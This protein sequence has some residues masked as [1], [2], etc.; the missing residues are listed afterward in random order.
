MLYILVFYVTRV[1][2]YIYVCYNVIFEVFQGKYMPPR[3][4][5]HCLQL[6]TFYKLAKQKKKISFYIFLRPN[7]RYDEERIESE[8]TS[9]TTRTSGEQL[10][11][12]AYL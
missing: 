6:C 8:I 11:A 5:C 10:I 7:F 9:L 1:Y 4:S 2:I 3:Q 12:A